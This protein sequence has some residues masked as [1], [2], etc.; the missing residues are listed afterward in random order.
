M[1]QPYEATL[2]RMRPAER[3]AWAGRVWPELLQL[4]R[5]GRPVVMLAGEI[6]REHLET[7][8][9]GGGRRPEA[10]SVPMRGL[11]VGEQ[12]AWLTRAIAQPE[13]VQ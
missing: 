2:L 6:Y 1:L 3:L 7:W 5:D 11:G 9:T 10:C 12:L 4:I 8:L 13:A